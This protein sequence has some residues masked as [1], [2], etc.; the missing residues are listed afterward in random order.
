MRPKIKDFIEQ[1]FAE[2]KSASPEGFVLSDEIEFE[3]S[4]V[5]YQDTDGK[6]DVK[7][8]SL[9]AKESNEAIQKIKF[10]YSNPE[11]G[12]KNAD[13]QAQV[14]QKMVFAFLEPLIE[15]GK[16]MDAAKAIKAK[17]DITTP[18]KYNGMGSR[19]DQ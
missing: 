18:E 19:V 2:L 10:T 17:E 6:F 3:I 1:T 9:G 16:Q 13:A 7:I 4:L 8:A 15:M 14:V 11:Q 12:L 5:T